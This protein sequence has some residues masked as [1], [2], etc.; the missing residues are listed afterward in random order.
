[1]CDTA[2][3][4]V[5]EALRRLRQLCA[6]GTTEAR[7]ALLV[8]LEVV[9]LPW[10]QVEGEIDGSSGTSRSSRSTNG[11][12]SGTSRPSSATSR[13]S[14]GALMHCSTAAPFPGVAEVG[15]CGLDNHGS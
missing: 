4:T 8:A 10:R 6:T 7:K 1:M 11:N 3:A 5:A 15:V 9:D 12:S 13:S 2:A 14:D